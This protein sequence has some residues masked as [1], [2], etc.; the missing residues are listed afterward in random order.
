MT[1]HYAMA[2]DIP[3]D[4]FIIDDFTSAYWDE[5]I[6][7]LKKGKT[8]VILDDIAGTGESLSSTMRCRNFVGLIDNDINTNL[9]WA[10]V[11]MTEKA[12]DRFE[13]KIFD[14]NRENSDTYICDV[15]AS[16]PFVYQYFKDRN[17]SYD[18]DQFLGGSG[19][20]GVATFVM[21]PFCISDTNAR[22][23]SAFASFF[24]RFPNQHVICEKITPTWLYTNTYDTITQQIGSYNEYNNKNT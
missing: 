8:Y 6:K 1:Y 16:K 7:P 15:Q 10:P 23:A 3:F 17:E 21:F 13:A 2:N 14:Y 11:Y 12:K 4:K 22:L 20:R 9:I 5:T 18:V 24:L 19:Y